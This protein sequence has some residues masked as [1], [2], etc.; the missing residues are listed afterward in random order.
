M[1]WYKEHCA[2]CV[3]ELG[4]EFSI[5]HRWLDEFAATWGDNHRQLRHH[6]IGVEQVRRMWGDRAA[7]AAEIH[8]KKDFFGSV[9]ED[10]TKVAWIMEGVT[11]WPEKKG[12]DCGG[13]ATGG[14]SEQVETTC[15]GVEDTTSPSNRGATAS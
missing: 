15:C 7:L 1:A 12:E 14:D 9:P 10:E 4:E 5:V 2:D 3:K 11:H 8:I 6:K 13:L